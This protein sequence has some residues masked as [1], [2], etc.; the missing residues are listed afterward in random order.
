VLDYFVHVGYERDCNNF[1]DTP[2]VVSLIPQPVDYFRVCGKTNACRLQCLSEFQAFE[3][4]AAAPAHRETV[5]EVVQSLVFNAAD[6]DTL[7]PLPHPM[8]LMEL[9]ACAPVCGTVSTAGAYRG[10]CFVLAG[11]NAHR[12]LEV[13]AF[14]APLEIGASVRRGGSPCVVQKTLFGLEI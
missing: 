12:A 3:A 2:Y 9:E 14:C 7:T 6:A 1:I 4:S 8:A 10:R 13:L 11:E 5:T